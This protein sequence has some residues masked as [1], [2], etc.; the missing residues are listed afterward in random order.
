MKSRSFP[1]QRHPL[2]SSPLGK[3]QPSVHK[4]AIH[5]G[6]C[7]GRSRGHRT[8]YRQG[9]SV[10][11]ALHFIL[12]QP[13]C[14]GRHTQ[15]PTFKAIVM[16]KKQVS[17]GLMIVPR[18]PNK[19]LAKPGRHCRPSGLLLWVLNPGTGWQCSSTTCTLQT[20]HSPA[21]SCPT[22]D[23]HGAL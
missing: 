2:S 17:R 9:P 19:S 13:E 6:Q 8:S 20:A 12:S 21:E 16:R 1:P 5:Q 4:L 11:R 15:E 3:A 7:A 18:S 22:Q 10:Q 23:C 14:C